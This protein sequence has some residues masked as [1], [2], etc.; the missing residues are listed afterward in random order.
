MG[1]YA[2]LL[3]SCLS[4]GCTSTFAIPGND[5]RRGCEANNPR[6][7]IMLQ[8]SEAAV[9]AQADQL[10]KDGDWD[11]AVRLYAK[12]N[13][14]IESVLLSILDSCLLSPST[15]TTSLMNSISSS[16]TASNSGNE[17]DNGPNKLRKRS[18]LSLLNLITKKQ[19]NDAKSNENSSKQ[20]HINLGELGISSRLKTINYIIIYLV[21]KLDRIDRQQKSMQRTIIATL[22]VQLYSIQ[23][24]S[25]INNDEKEELK[26]DFFNFLTDQ[27]E[28]LDFHT[29]VSI[30]I[31]ND[32]YDEAWHLSLLTKN[33]L[34][35]CELSTKKGNIDQCLSLLTLTSKTVKSPASIASASASKENSSA[36]PSSASNLI[37]LNNYDLLNQYILLV[38]NGLLYKSPKKIAG[39]LN[40]TLKKQEY[41]KNNYIN[42]MNI[43]Y[44]LTK[45]IRQHNSNISNNESKLKSEEAYYAAVNYIVDLILEL[46]KNSNS[47]SSTT[48]SN[49]DSGSRNNSSAANTPNEI[50]NTISEDWYNFIIFLFSLHAEFGTEK[51]AQK[52]FDVLML[53]LLKSHNQQQKQNGNSIDTN[54]RDASSEKVILL[55]KALSGILECCLPINYKRLCVY[56]YEG[57]EE[58]EKCIRT[59]MQVDLELTERK[60]IEIKQDSMKSHRLDTD[61]LKKLWCDLVKQYKNYNDIVGIVERSKGLLHIEDILIDMDNFDCASEKIKH[62]VEYSLQQHNKMANEAKD[63][64]NSALQ[65]IN[66]LKNDIDAAKQ[67]TQDQNDIETRKKRTSY[68]SC[69]HPSYYLNRRTMQCMLCGKSVIESIDMPFGRGLSLPV[70]AN[71]GSNKKK[72]TYQTIEGLKSNVKEG[73]GSATGKA[74]SSSQE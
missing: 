42:H 70:M 66:Y 47:A 73:Q 8:T 68:L 18:S 10:A 3:S 22:L 69:G 43:L 30:L 2:Q 27:H 5:F 16:N 61:T 20:Q 56:V 71:S 49:D 25:E 52:S 44:G 54:A 13:R 26:K 53:P 28:D 19:T 57:L 63:R 67:W 9:E 24:S 38:S 1:M 50:L 15:S 11:A 29:S 17:K 58:Y 7:N 74:S 23:L 65:I 59:A 72:L 21:Y 46:M 55:K 33:I 36:S 45:I 60:L 41:N 4:F 14:P 62:A 39:A 48:T 6:Q 40:K 34:Y 31:K 64:S 12:T 37:L 32:C 35:A 51:E